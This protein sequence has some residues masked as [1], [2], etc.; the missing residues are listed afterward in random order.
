MGSYH[1]IMEV[2]WLVAAL[3]S[4]GMVAWLIHNEGFSTDTAI[5][6]L[7]PMGTGAT[8]GLRRAVRKKAEKDQQKK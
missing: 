6:L 4:L 7:V 3:G 1:R 8:W 2:F 5:F